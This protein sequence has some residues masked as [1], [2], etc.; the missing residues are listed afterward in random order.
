MRLRRSPLHEVCMQGGQQAVQGAALW[1]AARLEWTCM[2][3]PYKAVQA[4]AVGRACRS[5]ILPWRCPPAPS[6]CQSAPRQR[7]PGSAA[8]PRRV[9]GRGCSA[10]GWSPPA[11]RSSAPAAAG[12]GMRLR[13]HVPAKSFNKRG[14]MQTRMRPPRPS[15]Q[16]Q[17]SHHSMR[18]LLPLR[19]RRPHAAMLRRL[20]Q[21]RS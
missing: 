18:W 11:A 4:K 7:R 13:A 17:C 16:V 20:L 3:V 15:Q 10:A 2:R 8:P 9:S 6:G 21:Q 14:G 12:C 1:L 19:T 5:P